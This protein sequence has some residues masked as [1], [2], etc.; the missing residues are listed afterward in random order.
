[1]SRFIKYKVIYKHKGFIIKNTSHPP[2]ERLEKGML[3]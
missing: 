2:P 3:V 1:M